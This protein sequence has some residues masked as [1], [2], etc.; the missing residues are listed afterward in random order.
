[1]F[2]GTNWAA[3]VSPLNRLALDRVMSQLV[4]RFAGGGADP[5][6][7]PARSPLRRLLA[8]VSAKM[9]CPHWTTSMRS[10]GRSRQA[11]SDQ[12]IDIDLFFLIP[13]SRENHLHLRHPCRNPRR[14][15]EPYRSDRHL[16]YAPD[17]RHRS[18]AD[19]HRLN[20]RGDCP[21]DLAV[22]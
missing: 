6:R 18:H 19:W 11:L 20:D 17:C 16:R 5:L 13:N 10:R 12:S 8:V 7:R 2:L 3:V 15:M 1:M 22:A 9:C 4:E 21:A 14:S